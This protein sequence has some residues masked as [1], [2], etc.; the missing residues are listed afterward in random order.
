MTKTKGLLIK[1]YNGFYYVKAENKLWSCSLRGRFRL[2]KQKFLPGDVVMF[3][4]IEFPKGVIEEVLPRK[5]QLVRPSIANVEQ[6]V[7]TF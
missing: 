2:T 1:G 7:I 5:N 3:T 6:A 4:E